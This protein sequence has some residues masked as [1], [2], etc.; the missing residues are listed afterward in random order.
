[1]KIDSM[2]RMIRVAL[3]GLIFALF[4]VM[5]MP[6]L[7]PILMAALFGF[8]LD[9]LV[10]KYGLKNTGR[11]LPTAIILIGFFLI[12][13]SPV[14]V[15]TYKVI[16]TVRSIS[17]GGLSNSATY[18]S[19]EQIVIS[20]N[21]LWEK[22]G[23][24]MHLDPKNFESPLA[25]FAK[26]G[27]LAVSATTNL[28]SHAPELILD[29]FIF[30]A[31]LYFFLTESKMIRKTVSSFRILTENELDQIIRIVQ[32]SSYVT[33]V[34]S[35]LVGTIQALIV[36]LGGLV[37]GYPEFLL[38]FVVTFF[39][40]LIPVIGA[41]PIAFLLA[42]LS[43]VQG[44]YGSAIGLAVVGLVA[45]SVDN[46]IKPLVVSSASFEEGL[47]PVVSLLAIIGA[48]IVYGL[49]GLLLGPV[50]TELTLKIVPILFA[51]DE[52]EESKA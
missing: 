17:D 9:S 40:S 52:S 44:E 24:N 31:A 18:Q 39:T 29:L 6:F 50:L 15:I 38:I 41:G 10:S 47:N 12:V 13:L 8:A 36:A 45:G 19:V 43:L 27:T 42:I 14:S 21:E 25:L 28:A 22:V 34:A 32:R 49:P 1:M 3:T 4:G 5:F 11:R 20:L 26:A 35:A 46:I 7:T 30:S 16:R 23:R 48:V 37:F 2:H 33:L 51:E